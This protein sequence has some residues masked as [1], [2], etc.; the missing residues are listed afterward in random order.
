M[1]IKASL[2][3]LLASAFLSLFGTSQ[4]NAAT[5]L[6]TLEVT[7]TTA[8]GSPGNPGYSFGS[9]PQTFTGTFEADDAVVGPISSL[10]IEIGGLDVV[11]ELP[12]LAGGNTFDPATLQLTYTIS[13]FGTNFPPGAFVAFGDDIVGA[14]SPNYVA[15]YQQ[16]FTFGE[17]QDPV[18]GLDSNWAGSYVITPIPEPTGAT[19]LL[20]G[21][22]LVLLRRR[23]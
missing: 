7:V 13:D 23:R 3:T 2:F 15:G 10:A 20:I 17:V 6:Y 22:G 8:P 9:L 5:L 21:T 11:A 18:F 1:K 12:F 4:M 19:L 16:T 14:P